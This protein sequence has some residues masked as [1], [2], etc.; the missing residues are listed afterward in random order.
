MNIGARRGP[1]LESR[2]TAMCLLM[3]KDRTDQLKCLVL[4]DCDMKTSAEPTLDVRRVQSIGWKI[5]L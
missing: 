3:G 5:F 4:L 2:V 1:L